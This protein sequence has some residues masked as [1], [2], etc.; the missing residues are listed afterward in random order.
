ML[1]RNEGGVLPL[2]SGSARIAVVG[3]LADAPHEQL[4]TW[5]YDGRA[6]DAVTPLAAL[7]ERLGERIA[8]APGLAYSR[9]RSRD[10]FAAAVAA[11]DGADV[12]L[13]FGGEEAVLSGEAHSR[14]DL[15][16]PGVQ[17]ELIRELAATGKPV[18]LVLLA[19]RPIAL[20]DVLGELAAVLVAWHPGT[21]GGPALAD[22]LLGDAPPSGRL[23]VSWPKAAG[24][25]PIYYGHKPTFG[26]P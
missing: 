6:E 14:A 18:V 17:E 19:G 9:D 22:L 11:A 7:R 10:G 1:L 26:A 5:S 21:M 20:H 8:Y 2:D 25:V 16:L 15:R 3:P 24:Q 12:V 23:P 4:G 13:F